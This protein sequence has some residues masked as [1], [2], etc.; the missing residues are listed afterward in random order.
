[1]NHN[2]G[3]DSES[4]RDGFLD[5]FLFFFLF[6]NTCS[7]QIVLLKADGTVSGEDR[8]TDSLPIVLGVFR[9]YLAG[10]EPLWALFSVKEREQH[11]PGFVF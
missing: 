6:L 1:M 9:Q 11:A 3:S 4:Q 8:Y 10:W 2:L 5:G 7:L